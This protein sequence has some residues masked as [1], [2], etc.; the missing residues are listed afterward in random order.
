MSV[1]TGNLALSAKL[2]QAPF[3]KEPLAASAIV[4]RPCT[5][6]K[7][8]RMFTKMQFLRAWRDSLGL[9]RQVVVDTLA[10]LTGTD[11]MDQAALGKWET[12]E[13]A[14]R[15]EDLQLLAQVY[16]T[17]P[18]RLFFAPDNKL[19]PEQLQ[20]AHDVIVSRSPEAVERWLAMGEMMAGKPEAK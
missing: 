8:R 19:T 1:M 11:P 13:T 20:R 9:S 15:V 5:M 16:G 12:G 7:R 17:T 6:T 10:Q 14:V 2:G 3:A 4:A 18:D